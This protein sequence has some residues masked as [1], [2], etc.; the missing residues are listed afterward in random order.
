MYIVG[1]NCGVDLLAPAR[2]VK[3]SGNS[4]ILGHLS[5][6]CIPGA[7]QMLWNALYSLISVI[8]TMAA[9]YMQH[10]GT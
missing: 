1:E 7:W 9:L 8:L 4:L 10:V 2:N 3:A 5:M 6:R